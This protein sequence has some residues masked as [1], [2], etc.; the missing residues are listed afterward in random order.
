MLIYIYNVL[1]Q[2]IGVGIWHSGEVL[3]VSALY[4]TSPY[5]PLNF[6]PPHT[7][8]MSAAEIY[9]ECLS[10]LKYGYP[11]YNL[12]PQPLV[13]AVTSIGRTVLALATL[14]LSNLEAIS[15][16]CSIFVTHLLVHC[17]RAAWRPTFL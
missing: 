1:P 9:A 3:F 12:K 2:P 14:E 6:T 11:M 5:H 4:V 7:I 15:T 8:A 10:H 17:A 13:S 16:F